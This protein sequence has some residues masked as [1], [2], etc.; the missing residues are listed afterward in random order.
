MLK[1]VCTHLGLIAFDVQMK[2]R[3]L[4]CIQIGFLCAWVLHSNPIHEQAIIIPSH[5][6][7]Y[8]TAN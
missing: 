3:E 5:L 2:N 8:S 6:I 1:C 4:A 7:A